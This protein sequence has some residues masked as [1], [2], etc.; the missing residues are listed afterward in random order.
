MTTTP[1]SEAYHPSRP[2]HLP[3]ESAAPNV[4]SAM[5][6]ARLGFA[7]FP[8]ITGGKA[9]LT[10]NGHH[11][12]SCCRNDIAAWWLR[13]PDANIGLSLDETIVV[14]DEDGP[15]GRRSLAGLA[16]PTTVTIATPRLGGF[17]RYY[18][19][20]VPLRNRVG[21][22]PGLDLKTH[23]GYVVAPPSFS[24]EHGRYWLEAP[25]LGLDDVVIADAPSWLVEAGSPQPKTQRPVAPA[26]PHIDA[27]PYVTAALRN[28]VTAVATAPPGSRNNQLNRSA[29]ALGTLIAGGL[30][31]AD[32]ATTALLDAARTAGLGVSEAVKTVASGVGAGV[33]NPRVI[34]RG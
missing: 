4:D 5:R 24:A 27:P 7:V 11:D 1:P 28:E 33:R 18:R 19:T 10:A 31:S 29:F 22:R 30:L 2:L 21:F 15:K 9:P 20:S 3:T 32:T 14:L 12:A 8:V 16:V 34:P 23:G 25:G 6:L 26:S 13:W 17:H